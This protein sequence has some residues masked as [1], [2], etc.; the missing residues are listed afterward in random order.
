MEKIVELDIKNEYDL[1]DKYNG[2]R[3]SSELISYIIDN[4]Y[5]FIKADKIVLVVNNFLNKE[6]DCK[7]L[8]DEGL[9][10]EYDKSVR[11]HQ[12]N[13][14]AQIFYLVV[15]ILTL[16]LST[17]I[18]EG[19]FKEL[20]VIGGWVFIWE[21][22]EVELFSEVSGLKKRRVIKKILKCPIVE[23]KM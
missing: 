12:R 14:L 8:I 4:A 6:I 15:G 3:A 11:R 5:P 20:I 19:I 13:N 2:N 9:R 1:Y 10:R 23:R 16:F 21:L 7:K 22:V 18:S 17:L